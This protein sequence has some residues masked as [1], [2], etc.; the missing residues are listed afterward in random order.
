MPLRVC[1]VGVLERRKNATDQFDL[2]RFA[3]CSNMRGIG[4]HGGE[5]K[6][7]I[8]LYRLVSTSTDWC[9]QPPLS[10]SRAQIPREPLAVHD[11]G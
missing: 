9:L 6:T 10:H 1:E 4:D 2:L 3:S 7:T 8:A 11:R 5:L